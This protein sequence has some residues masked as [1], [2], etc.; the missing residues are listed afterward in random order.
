MAFVV[1]FFPQP[2]GRLAEARS[3]RSGVE[4]AWLPRMAG[5]GCPRTADQVAGRLLTPWKNR[6]AFCGCSCVGSP[7][8]WDGELAHRSRRARATYPPT[9]NRAGLRC[10]SG[11]RFSMR[12]TGRSSRPS[13]RPARGSLF[14][15]PAHERHVRVSLVA[16][17]AGGR[18]PSRWWRS[19]RADRAGGG[20]V[21]FGIGGAARPSSRPP[22]AASATRP[23][24]QTW[25]GSPVTPRPTP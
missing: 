19:C 7:G 3:G 11:R 18:V 6:R 4:V 2:I 16:C 20:G 12:F 23:M 9:E 24:D 21:T 8:G 10:T 5:T 14:R 22:A 1:E 15:P 25:D 13:R 17:L